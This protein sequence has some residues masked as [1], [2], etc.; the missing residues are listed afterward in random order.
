[1]ASPALR[2]SR[3]TLIS[4]VLI[5]R[6]SVQLGFLTILPKSKDPCVCKRQQ[7]CQI[8]SP[9]LLISKAHC[10]QSKALQLAS[11]QVHAPAQVVDLL[12]IPTAR[13]ITLWQTSVLLRIALGTLSTSMPQRLVTLSQRSPRA[14]SFRD[15]LSRIAVG[16]RESKLKS[17]FKVHCARRA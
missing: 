2:R 15:T 11:S 6:Q 13:A 10:S 1:M 8:V 3:H 14:A 16:R 7:I 9:T 17:C 5:G 12:K 4:K